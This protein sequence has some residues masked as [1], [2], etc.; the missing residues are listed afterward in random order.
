[1]MATLP[2]LWTP[3]HC[4]PAVPGSLESWGKD[5]TLVPGHGNDGQLHKRNGFSLGMLMILPP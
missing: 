4:L 5:V 1:M 3:Y 2:R